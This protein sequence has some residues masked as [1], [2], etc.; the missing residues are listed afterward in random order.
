MRDAAVL[1]HRG[2]HPAEIQAD[3]RSD[4]LPRASH[5]GLD[6]AS[7]IRRRI[8]ARTRLDFCLTLHW[9]WVRTTFAEQDHSHEPS[10]AANE[11]VTQPL[12]Q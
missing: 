4:R 8:W 2:R 12:T 1:R 11:P 3:N 5:G 6:R 10:D 7:T 9:D